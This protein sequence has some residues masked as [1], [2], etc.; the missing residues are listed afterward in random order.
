MTMELWKTIH[1][2]LPEISTASYFTYIHI[3]DTMNKDAQAKTSFTLITTVKLQ[4]ARIVMLLFIT[5]IPP[6]VV[7][8][9]T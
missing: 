4:Q 8:T 3:F 2:N 5:L 9:F 6:H 1:Y 7:K